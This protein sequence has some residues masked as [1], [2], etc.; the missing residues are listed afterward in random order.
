MPRGP[1]RAPYAAAMTARRRA[2]L[3]RIV[4]AV[5]LAVVGSLLAPAPPS[6][7]LV[8]T[9]V[10]SGNSFNPERMKM[11][12][13]GMGLGFKNEDGVAHTATSDDGFFDTGS[14]P[15]DELTIV[16]F[17]SSGKF[18]YHCKFHGSMTARVV[19]PLDVLAGSAAEGWKLQWSDGPAPA[20]RAFDVQ[21]RRKNASTWRDL[22]TNTTHGSGKFNPTRSGHYLVRARTS[23]TKPGH[24]AESG[25]SPNVPLTIS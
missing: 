14:I 6:S 18:A 17:P 24:K 3:P 9:V 22:R 19:V 2:H 21:F 20:D 15:P 10:I 7:S 11:Q 4:A 25:W 1:V 23:N 13:T 5:S 16:V 12:S 8:A